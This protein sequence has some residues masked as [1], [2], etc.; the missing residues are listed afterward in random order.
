MTAIWF[1]LNFWAS[2]TAFFFTYYVFEERGWTADSLRLLMPAA[3]PFG[4]LGQVLAGRLMDRAGRRPAAAVFICLGSAAALLCYRSEHA[5][6]IGAGWVAL[7]ALQGVWSIAQTLTVELFPTE[8]RASASGL[9]H[10]LLGRWGLVLGPVAVGT[11]AAQLGSTAAAVSVLAFS[12]LLA[13]P[14]LR[15]LPETRGI[16]LE[17]PPARDRT[18]A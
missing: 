16:S 15:T 10:N 4:F 1:S 3:L 8:L 13:L 9:T 5:W 7:Q 6:A 12:N 17:H 2:S 11:L 14:A 18:D